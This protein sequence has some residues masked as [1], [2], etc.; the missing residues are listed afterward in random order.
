MDAHSISLLAGAVCAVAALILLISKV[1]LNPFVT[2]MVVSLA[3]GLFSGLPFGSVVKSFEAGV[4]GTLGH[5]AI[6]VGLG[7]MLGK[8]MAE[9][10]AAEQIAT[11]VITRF[12]P[13]N[14]QWSMMLIGLVVGLPAFFEVGFVLLIPIAYTAARETGRHPLAV[15]L[16]MIAALSVDHALV[17]PHPAAM[18][19]ISIYHGDV[20]RMLGYALLI[21]IPSAILAGPVYTRWLMPRL[22]LSDHNTIADELSHHDAKRRLPS[23][24]R[25]IS[26]IL[27]PV[28]LMLLGSIA[29]THFANLT[30]ALGVISKTLA[31]VGNDDIALLIA[32]LASFVTLGI[33][34]GF[35][36]ETISDWSTKCLAPTAAITLLVGAGGG[37]GR[38]LMDGGVA[39][40]LV[41][42][43]AD[44]HI[45]VLLFA[46]T[47]AALL[48][49]ATGS[50]TVAMTTAAGIVAP[51]ALHT[52]HTN[53]ALLAIVTGAGSVIWSHVNDGFFWLV[54]E[55]MRLSV[56]ETFKSWSVCETIISVTG[57]LACLGL[58]LISQRL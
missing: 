45:N 5:I 39:K 1:R 22:A 55:Y 32:V 44:M 57:L 28:V 31:F 46:W 53:P 18:L 9:S 6:V 23:F 21:G 34:A 37:F 43:A 27:L 3:L 58:N 4:G 52:P 47:L 29:Q 54:K 35:N 11:T 42:L 12:G 14:I 25:A 48:R 2:L 38:V 24:S 51:I 26:T 7:T 17:P 40:V 15:A 50:S 56:S 8:M 13:Q 30:G 19:A 10:G 20:G 36:R 49:L 41:S 16:P 33:M